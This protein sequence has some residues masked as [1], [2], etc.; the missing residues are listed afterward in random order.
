MS[1]HITKQILEEYLRERWGPDVSIRSF[2]TLGEASAGP[3]LKGFGYGSPVMIEALVG[4]RAQRMV[5]ETMRPGPNGHEHMADRAHAM[6]WDYATYNRLPRHARALDVGA[7]A[8]GGGV[9]SVG[10]AREF[11][12]LTEFVAGKEYQHDLARIA[13]TGRLDRQDLS[14]ARALADYLAQIHRVKKR[15]PGLYVRALRDLIGHGECL[16]GV[17]DTY[18]I[19]SPAHPRRRG[20]PPP[21]A[22]QDRLLSHGTRPFPVRFITPALLESIE[23]RCNA[24][25]WRLRGNTGRLSQV[26]G[27]FHPWNVLFRKGADF[28][29][30]DRSRAEW[31][32]PADDVTA[33]TINYVFFSV[34]RWGDLRGPFERLFRLFWDRYLDR[35]GDVGVLE[36]APPY[37]TFR[38]LVI[39]S[40]VWYP[41]LTLRVRRSLFNFIENVLDQPRFDPARVNEYL[42]GS[43]A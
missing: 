15:A 19:F 17:V 38:G 11:F 23:A 2:G 1:M 42:K 6:L 37:Y 27:D 35:T 9:R 14:R 22:C 30:L 41:T 25:R 43:P 39:A 5:L 21:L 31:G 12:V 36:A 13:R 20:T 16:M 24:W 28:S 40:P 3:V 7:F 32:E 10:D 8:A 33:M 4:G 26:H 18:P 29:V 34:R